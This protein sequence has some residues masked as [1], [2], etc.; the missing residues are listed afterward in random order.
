MKIK[1]IKPITENEYQFYSKKIKRFLDDG[2]DLV[3]HEVFGLGV[4]FNDIV[5]TVSI[6]DKINI[7]ISAKINGEDYFFNPTASKKEH[8]IQYPI[9]ELKNLD[10]ILGIIKEIVDKVSQSVW[11]VHKRQAEKKKQEEQEAKEK[12]RIQSI[13]FNAKKA[14]IEMIV[15]LLSKSSFEELDA[16]QDL[17]IKIK[18]SRIPMTNIEALL[19]L[20]KKS[21]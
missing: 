10:N 4:I 12:E 21:K 9:S 2:L 14:K 16:A 18:E 1:S 17:L 19:K 6:V 20:I 11:E 15:D 7:S 13:L 5:P 8:L 3:A